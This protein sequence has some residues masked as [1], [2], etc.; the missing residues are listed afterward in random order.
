MFLLL[1]GLDG[2]SRVSIYGALL[3]PEHDFGDVKEMMT[4]KKY[5]ATST[6]YKLS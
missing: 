4:C 3:V 1:Q 2:F 5:L 6:Y